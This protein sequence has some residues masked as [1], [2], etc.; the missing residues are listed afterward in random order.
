MPRTIVTL[1]TYNEAENI[2]LLIQELR[3]LGLEVLVAEDNSPDGTWRIVAEMGEADSGVYLLHRLEKKGRGFA[4]AEAFSRALELGAE[5]IVEMDADFS[6][7]PRFIPDLLRALDSGADLA[8]GS[9]LVP[10]GQDVGR[11][12]FRVQLTRFSCFYARLVLGLP[13]H[14][15]N[16]GFRAFTRA[17]ME[18]IRPDTLIS[19]GPSIVHEVFA[20]AQRLGL[21]MTEIP[22]TFVERQRGTSELTLSR[23]LD[24]FVKVWRI[25]RLGR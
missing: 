17:A 13:I 18:K 20:R 9:R 19:A 8:V 21:R 25:R 14:D 23:L 6:H 7:Q 3:A 4:G 2:R 24:G 5:R 10:G 12:W 11:G 16:S 22:I 1:P 15:A